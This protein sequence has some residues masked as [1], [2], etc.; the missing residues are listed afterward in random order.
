M[1][2][3]FLVQHEMRKK[4]TDVQ[5]IYGESGLKNAGPPNEAIQEAG[6]LMRQV[7]HYFLS[8]LVIH[9]KYSKRI[10]GI[11]KSRQHEITCNSSS[12]L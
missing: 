1:V 2:S 11:E 10:S 8:P 4:R 12:S 3:A 7:S 5:V 9:E 6:E